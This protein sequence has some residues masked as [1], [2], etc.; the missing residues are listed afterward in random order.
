M[1]DAFDLLR[2]PEGPAPPDRRPVWLLVGGLVA[3]VLLAL[4]GVVWMVSS[5]SGGGGTVTAGAT[6]PATTPATTSAPAVTAAPTTTPAATT[7]PP[8]PTTTVPRLTVVPL[9]S[10]AT[11]APSPTPRRTPAPTTSRPLP[12]PTPTPVGRLVPVPDVV[13]LRV[14]AAAGVLRAQG[15]KVQV[16]GGV[17]GPDRDDRRVTAQRP[18]AGAV[19]LA[20]STVILVTD[21][22]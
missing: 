9:P 6:T 2:D 1:D 4:V 8:V 14:T 13:G 15:F 7:R 10:V 20:G 5:V 22:L 21:G 16:L 17:L 11:L 3:V 18:R 12:T 19:V